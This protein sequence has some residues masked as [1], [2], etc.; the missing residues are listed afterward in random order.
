MPGYAP[1]WFTQYT[2]LRRVTYPRINRARRRVTALTETNALNQTGSQK[3]AVTSLIRHNFGLQLIKLQSNIKWRQAQKARPTPHCRALPPCEF[4]GMFSEPLR[5]H[6]ESFM[7]QT[8]IIAD[9][10]T[11]L[12]DREQY[13]SQDFCRAMLCISAA[14]AVMRCLCVSVCLSR[15]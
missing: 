11:K 7:T 9:K 1:R 10:N 13:T 4:N 12:G 6:F 15:S 3:S 14:Y 8:N 5:V 2:S